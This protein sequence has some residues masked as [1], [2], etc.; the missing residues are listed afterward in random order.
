MIN[1]LY[2]AFSILAVN[3]VWV[4]YFTQRHF[5]ADEDDEI[6]AKLEISIEKLFP[7]GFAEVSYSKNIL[8]FTSMYTCFL[9]R[10][11]IE[12]NDY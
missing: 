8:A 10:L 7:S 4:S 11:N 3:T 9:S 2:T 12:Y 1:C 5:D 6:V